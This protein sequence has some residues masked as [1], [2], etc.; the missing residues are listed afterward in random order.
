MLNKFL[1]GTS[2]INQIHSS[3]FP[4]D[5]SF[6]IFL[7]VALSYSK[8]NLQNSF[9]DIRKI[10]LGISLTNDPTELEEALDITE[11]FGKRSNIF[12]RKVKSNTRNFFLQRSFETH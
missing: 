9:I 11:I 6:S 8:I 12:F 3:L 5:F 10:G 1:H 7:I 2:S 4:R